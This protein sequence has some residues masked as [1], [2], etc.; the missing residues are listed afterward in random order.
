MVVK[1]IA[2]VRKKTEPTATFPKN[3]AI[4]CYLVLFGNKIEATIYCLK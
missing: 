1:N 4:F 3:Y 2:K